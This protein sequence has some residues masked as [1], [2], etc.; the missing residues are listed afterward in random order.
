MIGWQPDSRLADPARQAEWRL[1]VQPVLGFV[2]LFLPQLYAGWSTYGLGAE[3]VATDARRAEA[4]RATG[5][6]VVPTLYLSESL[7]EPA[8][9]WNDHLAAWCPGVAAFRFGAMDRSALAAFAGFPV[10]GPKPGPKPEPAPGPTIEQ[11]QLGLIEKIV[12]GEYRAA[13][14]DLTKIVGV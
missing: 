6:P 1:V 13:R 11:V 5:K 4:F 2:D 12:H 7:A 9:L 3:A 8:A 10:G 14:D